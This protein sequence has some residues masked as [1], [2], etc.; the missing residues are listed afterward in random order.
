[1]AL[2]HVVGAEHAVGAVPLSV[3]DLGLVTK[4]NSDP[5]L[6]YVVAVAGPGVRTRVFVDSHHGAVLLADSQIHDVLDDWRR[7]AG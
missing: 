4:E 5:R 1:V 6:V 2:D 3:F 7:R